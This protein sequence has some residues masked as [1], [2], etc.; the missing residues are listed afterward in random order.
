MTPRRLA[1]VLTESA[2]GYAQKIRAGRHQWTADEPK[3][4]GGTESGPNP[5]SLLL[6][7]LG[8]CTSITLR[9]YAEGKGWKLGEV[10]VDLNLFKEGEAD[11]IE[12]QIRFSAPLDGEQL[13]R[14]AEVADKT[15]VTK[16]VRQGAPI[17]TSVHSGGV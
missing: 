14:L 8:A 9:M 5:Y 6:G 11:R 4:R 13:A 10:R 1:H 3:D 17:Q 2:A 7:A 12:R 16:T 15:P